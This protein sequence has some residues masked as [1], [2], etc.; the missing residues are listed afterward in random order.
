MVCSMCFIRSSIS[1]YR[2][3][4][5]FLNRI[6]AKTAAASPEE[7][8]L[9]RTYKLSF[10]KMPTCHDAGQYYGR[11]LVQNW[12]CMTHPSTSLLMHF[13]PLQKSLGSQSALKMLLSDCSPYHCPLPSRWWS[14]HP[15]MGS[16]IVENMRRSCLSVSSV[17]ALE[18]H[19]DWKR[20]LGSALPQHEVECR[21]LSTLRRTPNTRD[22]FRLSPAFGCRVARRGF[23]TSRWV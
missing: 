6:S 18:A 17:S 8:R 3:S 7:A 2:I 11:I 5:S 23:H 4:A 22:A 12:L 20:C 1:L 21:S 16:K 13:T 9:K 19:L 15:P 10:Q 14:E